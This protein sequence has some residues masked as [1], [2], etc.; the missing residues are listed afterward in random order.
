[1]MAMT[2]RSSIS[3]NAPLRP[4]VAFDIC[5]ATPGRTYIISVKYSVKSIVGEPD[6]GHTCDYSFKTLRD[7]VVVDQITN[8][9]HLVKTNN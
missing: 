6:P 3:V 2:T 1:M 7:G 5:G 8:A 4:G 9:L